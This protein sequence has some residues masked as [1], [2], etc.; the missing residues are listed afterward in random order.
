[1][2]RD[3]PPSDFTERLAEDRATRW[4]DS[5]SEHRA[6]RAESGIKP[7]VS[8]PGSARELQVDARYLYFY[9]AQDKPDSFF[10]RPITAIGYRHSPRRVP[11]LMTAPPLLAEC[12]KAATL[13]LPAGIAPS[14]AAKSPPD[15]R[16]QTGNVP[17][18][19]RNI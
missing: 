4:R 3:G 18:F 11:R 7:P 14:G 6:N 13:P 19:G 12:E 17:F 15:G 10:F 5:S 16:P 1:M 9:A 2:T 8:L